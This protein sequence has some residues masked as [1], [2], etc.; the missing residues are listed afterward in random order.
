MEITPKN[1]QT[2]AEITP[3]LFCFRSIP[4]ITVVVVIINVIVVTFVDVEFCC[5]FFGAPNEIS[6]QFLPTDELIP[7]VFARNFSILLFGEFRE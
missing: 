2:S 3:F 1:K 5:F 4:I 6:A 7:R